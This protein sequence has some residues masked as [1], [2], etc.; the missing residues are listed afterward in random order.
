MKTL[1]L[2]DKK[3]RLFY[4]KSEKKKIILKYIFSNL[5]L[6]KNLRM[7]AY[8]QLKSLPR[9]CSITRIKNRCLLTNRSRSIYKKF[10]ISRLVFRRM[11]LN[12][13][14]VGVRKSTW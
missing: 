4:Q 14:L 12:G 13:E 3:R 8:Y 6:P 11:A 1:F 9:D 5:N 7:R 10:R 2:K